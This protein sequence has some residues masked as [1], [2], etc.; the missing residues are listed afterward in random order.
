M[1]KGI[2]VLFA[3]VAVGAGAFLTTRHHQMRP[4]GGAVLLDSMPE[5]A[6]LR[7]ELRLS[8]AQ[9]AEASR[10]H[11]DYRPKCEEMCRRIMDAHAALEAIARR[12][13]SV[14]PELE[15][16]IRDHARVHAECQQSMLE[17]IYRTA[18]L[19]D[20]KQARRYLETVLPAAMDHRSGTCGAGE[21][22]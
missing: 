12:N 8:D 19:M 18:A 20:D 13:R 14:T 4:P 3:A 10:L 7:R 21:S 17:H 2:L 1:N 6:W 22:H 9:F 16:A 11:A 5:L 15:H